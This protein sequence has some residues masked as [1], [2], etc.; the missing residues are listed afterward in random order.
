[1]RARMILCVVLAVSAAVLS[2]CQNVAKE[3]EVFKRFYLTTL[4]HSTA[5]DVLGFINE[6]PDEVLCQN[7]RTAASWGQNKEGTQLWFNMVAFDEQNL[8]AYRKYCFTTNEKAKGYLVSPVQRLR[9]DAEVVLDAKTVDEPYASENLRRVAFM[10]E[11]FEKFVFDSD[12]LATE[13]QTLKSCCMMTKEVL[14]HILYVLGRSPSLASKL[15]DYDGLEFDHIN[16]G[17]GKVRM[18]Y[19]GDVVK[20]KVKIG[21]IIKDFEQQP[22]VA[23]M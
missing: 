2:G 21:T 14:N 15:S 10:K 19:E 8:T 7:E 1:M 9:F 11:V 3:D 17:K 6:G 20:V 5:A 22:D 13:S 4:K 23:A 12:Q 16:Y 18:V